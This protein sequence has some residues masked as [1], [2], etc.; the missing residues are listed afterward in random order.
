MS[1]RLLDIGCGENPYKDFLAACVSEHVDLDYLKTFHN[2]SSIDL[3][4]SAYEIPEPG[5]SFDCGLCTA[6]IEH[7]EESE[8]EPLEC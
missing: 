7:F 1:G 6:V 8:L 5:G 3:F 2:E 4:T